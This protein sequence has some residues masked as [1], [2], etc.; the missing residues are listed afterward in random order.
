V[1]ELIA[2]YGAPAKL[3]S[4][5]GTHFNNRLISET[6]NLL[7]ISQSLTTAYHPQADS[8]TERFNQTLVDMIAKYVENNAKD[9]DELIPYVLFGYC[10][11]IHE[12]TKE[13][14]FYL[15]FGRDPV[16]PIDVAL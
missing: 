5:K 1:E 10:T 3:I 2:R 7:G 14:P 12:A 13:S 15:M 4:D 16:L 6:C 9:W 11:V 8:Q